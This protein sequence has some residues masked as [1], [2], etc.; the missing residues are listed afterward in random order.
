MHCIHTYVDRAPEPRHFSL[1]SP[2]FLFGTVRCCTALKAEGQETDLAMKSEHLCTL[3]QAN[4]TVTSP[5]PGRY[6]RESQ[7][8]REAPLRQPKVSVADAIWA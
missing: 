4:A 3:S 5:S 7:F 1:A 2:D 6:Y 8:G